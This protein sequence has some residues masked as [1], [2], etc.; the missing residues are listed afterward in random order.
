[1]TDEEPK[2]IKRR[3]SPRRARGKFYSTQDLVAKVR[4]LDKCRVGIT[5]I[6]EMCGVT[7]RTVRNILRYS[8]KD[9]PEKG[10]PDYG[11][12][13]VIVTERGVPDDVPRM[14]LDL[15]PK[16]DEPWVHGASL[17][18][19]RISSVRRRMIDAIDEYSGP[20]RV[21]KLTFVDTKTLSEKK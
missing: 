3:K 7:Y 5:R 8:P 11:A 6:A 16:L 14:A 15:N 13:Y 17:A 2:I 21:A 18:D 19:S 4:E 10:M 1:M 12:Y 9:E 20:V